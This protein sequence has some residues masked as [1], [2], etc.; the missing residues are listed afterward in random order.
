MSQAIWFTCE[1]VLAQGYIS[2]NL[3]MR[4]TYFVLEQGKHSYSRSLVP[5]PTSGFD[6]LQ[7]VKQIMASYPGRGYNSTIPNLCNPPTNTC[8]CRNTANLASFPGLRHPQFSLGL[9]KSLF[10]FSALFYLCC[11]TLSN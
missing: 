4:V 8:Q 1:R 5:R 11:S 2:C 7:C 3:T 10:M 9:C 6:C